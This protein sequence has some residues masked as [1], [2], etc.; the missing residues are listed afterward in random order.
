MEIVALMVKRYDYLYSLISTSILYILLISIFLPKIN[1]LNISKSAIRFED[2][3]ILIFIIWYYISNKIFIRN[4][5]KEISTASF[6]LILTYFISI[7]LNYFLFGY[8]N[9][10][11]ILYSFRYIE[12]YFYIYVG[13]EIYK[14]KLSFY[15]LLFFYIFFNVLVITLQKFGFIGGFESGIYQMDVMNRPIG[16]T[17]GPWEIALIISFGILLCL[18][19]YF[20]ILFWLIG[21]IL[22]E[23]R[24]AIIAICICLLTY[25]NS[26]IRKNKYILAITLSIIVV[27]IGIWSG[28]FGSIVNENI[29]G[30]IVSIYKNIDLNNYVM[31]EPNFSLLDTQISDYSFAARVMKWVYV[32][33]NIA[34]NELSWFTGL[35]PGYF[36]VAVDGSYV[37]IL[38]ELGSLGLISYLYLFKKISMVSQKTKLFVVLIM[39]NGLFIDVFYSSRIMP[40]LFILT[41][42]E[43]Y[44]NKLS[45]STFR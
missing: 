19:N 34:V 44:K 37:R 21:L 27:L 18:N 29:L 15:N 2:I 40:I 7:V 10:N 4:I 1:I 28:R 16:F 41:G 35:G 23:S 3:C 14:K 33:K 39:I 36:G 9:T 5:N 13:L 43:I 32:F 17:S 26:Y 30:T 8:Y 11:E 31:Y 42:Y 6:F 45:H 38:G 20:V 12:Y 24:I 25:K 22:T